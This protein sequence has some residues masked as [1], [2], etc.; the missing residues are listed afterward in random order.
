MDA[1]REPRD[2][3]PQGSCGVNV[4]V[5]PAGNAR[6]LCR[7]CFSTISTPRVSLRHQAYPLPSG[8]AGEIDNLYYVVKIQIPI[9]ADKD[10]IRD[11]QLIERRQAIGEFR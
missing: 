8:A 7:R 4:V 2:R 5:T 1:G 11:T 10:M 3:E 9:S 6:G